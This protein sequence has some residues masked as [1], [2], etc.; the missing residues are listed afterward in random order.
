MTAKNKDKSNFKKK[1]LKPRRR[2]GTGCSEVQP[3][4]KFSTIGS[5]NVANKLNNSQEKAF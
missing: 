1:I 3:R 5:P 2:I 4:D